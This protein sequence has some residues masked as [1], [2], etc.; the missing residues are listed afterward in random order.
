MDQVLDVSLTVDLEGDINGAFIDSQRYRP[1]GEKAMWRRTEEGDSLGLGYILQSLDQAE[2]TAT[3]FLEVFQAHCFG[4]EPLKEVATAME[5]AGQDIQ[6]HL[7]PCWRVFSQ[8][9]WAETWRGRSP[10]DTLVGLDAPL[11]D[12]RL[13]EA[14]ELFNQIVGRTP[15]AFRAGGLSVDLP[16]LQAVARAGISLTSCVGS[17]YNW[18]SEPSL[19]RLGGV[20]A[21]AGVLEV[22]VRS[23]RL[24][25]WPTAPLRLLTIIGSTWQEMEAVLEAAWRQQSGPVVILTH[26]SEFASN[27]NLATP[28]FE[29]NHQVRQRWQRLLAFLQENRSRYRVTPFSEGASRW[30]GLPLGDQTSL[31]APWTTPLVRFW[32]NRLS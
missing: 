10:A 22:P 26:P 5:Q 14:V 2:L 30:P 18:S 11:L 6:L 9:D 24:F 1:L 20:H 28:R 12:E 21:V 13:A 23:Y 16:L 32:Q 8:A 7:H 3:F 19:Q 4:L 31:S 17:G 27:Q 25:P 29:A 15:L